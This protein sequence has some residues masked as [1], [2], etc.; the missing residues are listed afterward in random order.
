M[1]SKKRFKEIFQHTLK[2]EGGEKLHNVKGDS[3][4]WT[5]YGIA[6]NLNKHHFD[7]LDDF[8]EMDYD[9]AAEIAYQ[10]YAL[11]ISL[12]LVN[13]ESQ[14]MFFDMAFN[15]G[16]KSAIKCAQRALNLDADGIVG[17]NTKAALISLD[18]EKLYYQR[19]AYY[20]RVV[21]NNA[22]QNKFLKGWTNRSNYFLKTEI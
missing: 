19:M 9:R 15:M 16:V 10:N 8:K 21:T 18:K 12:E 1:L 14:A 13:E 20:Q 3:G 17:K 4:G 5:K 2:W 11:P 7:S 22:T 6:Y